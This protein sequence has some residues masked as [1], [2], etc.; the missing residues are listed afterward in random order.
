[1]AISVIFVTALAFA[2]DSTPVVDPA[3]FDSIYAWIVGYVPAKTLTIVITVAWVFDYIVT[4]VKWTPAN[5]TAELVWIWL[6]KAV[7]FLSGKKK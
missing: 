3:F 7:H 6:K 5:S 2:Q 1:M 4:Y